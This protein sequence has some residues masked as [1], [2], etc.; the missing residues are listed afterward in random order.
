MSCHGS[1]KHDLLDIQ[2]KEEKDAEALE[3]QTQ[4]KQAIA[5][6]KEAEEKERQEKEEENEQSQSMIQ[7]GT[8]SEADYGLEE[9][10]DEYEIEYEVF[11][12]S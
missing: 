8:A 3:H 9:E 10:G 1:Y 12:T 5:A 2:T 4:H 7:K 6:A 11:Y